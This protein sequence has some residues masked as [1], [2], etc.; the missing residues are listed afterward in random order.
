MINV[1]NVGLQIEET[2]SGNGVTSEVGIMISRYTRI[3]AASLMAIGCFLLSISVAVAADTP[4]D[5]DKSSFS[6]VVSSYDK[7]SGQVTIEYG[8]GDEKETVTVQ[9]GEETK[10]L[11]QDLAD[12]SVVT[13][14]GEF[15]KGTWQATVGVVKP[16]KPQLDTS[17]GN[18]VGVSVEG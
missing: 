4:A 12:G 17:V 8:R 5:G 18:A 3:R 10:M 11:G 7:A 16:N 2:P 9:I 14:R 15:K 1:V 13:M 6:G